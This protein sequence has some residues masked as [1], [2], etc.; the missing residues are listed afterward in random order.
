MSRRKNACRL[1]VFTAIM[2]T[3]GNV[4]AAEFPATPPA[5]GPAPQLSVPTPTAQTLANG[6]QVVSV[7]R[8]GLPL[9]TAQLIVRSGGEMDPPS[10]AGLADLTANLLSKG[11]AGRSAPQIAAAAEALGGSLDA[12]AGW[13]ESAVGITVTT[14]KLAQA[15]G[16]LAKVVRQPDF[17][18]EELKRAQ[19]QSLDDLRLTLSRPTALASLAASRGVFGD[20][21]YGHSRGGT[22]ASIARIGR[23]DVQRLH[24]TLYRPDNAILVL[25]GDITPAQAQQL[26]EASFGDWRKPATPL[27]ARP[28]GKAVS[29]LPAVLLIDQRGA[30]QAGVVAAH[31]APSRSDDGYY[32]G[33]LAN[34]VLGGSYSARLNEE[35]RIKRGLSYGAGSRF[36]PLRDAGLWLAS[37]QTKNP[38]AAPVVELV[39]G[40]FKRLGDSRVGADELAARKATLIGG[41]GRSLETTAGLAERV[42]ELAVYGVPLDEI[43]KY[44]AKVQAVTPKQIEKYAKQHLAA[45]AATVVVVG[46]AAQFAADIRKAHPQAALLQSTALDLDSPTL[47]L[48]GSRK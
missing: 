14:P 5:P 31:A 40:E 30:G 18:A 20:G 10:L 16:L 39:L 48:A 36:Q 17:S 7:R 22:P 27:P 23:A 2:A 38:S 32:V 34:A 24:A 21:A 43:G 33:T 1:A 42:G 19:T 47:Q 11:A 35:I 25:A 6:L 8:A 45:G 12:A 29:R 41:Y 44:I 13:D 4:A 3:A 15:L 9:V 37:A 28:A 46:D 26:A